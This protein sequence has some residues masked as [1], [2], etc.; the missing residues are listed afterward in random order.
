[1]KKLLLALFAF[2]AFSFGA[3]AAVNLNTATKEELDTV[4]G[5]GPVK[6][7][8]IIDYRK[9]HGPFKSVDD[10]KNVRGFGGKTVAKM[11]GGLTVNGASSTHAQPAQAGSKQ[12]APANAGQAGQ[13]GQKHN[14]KK[15]KKKGK[16]HQG[17]KS[18]Q[19]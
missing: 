3:F 17:G 5:I 4:K 14:K 8:A 16:K 1:M 2:F 9:Q 19:Q 10:L 11:R 7:Q 15:G 18:A 12:A 6:A 13:D